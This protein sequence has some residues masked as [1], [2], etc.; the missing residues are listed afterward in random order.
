M[1]DCGRSHFVFV[2]CYETGYVLDHKKMTR[3]TQ[4]CILVVKVPLPI[5]Q[6]KRVL[7]NSFFIYI[8][9]AA[10]GKT[11]NRYWKIIEKIDVSITRHFIE[12]SVAQGSVQNVKSHSDD[13]IALFLDGK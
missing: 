11:L 8:I 10:A 7:K 2:T 6:E 9:V 4:K 13:R 12:I 1:K 5:Y 3:I